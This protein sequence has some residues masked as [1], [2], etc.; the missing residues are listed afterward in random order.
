MFGKIGNLAVKYRAWV[1]AGWVIAA[2]CLF[3]LA[4]PLSQVGTM[5]ESNFLPEDSESLRARALI[6]EYFPENQA[7]STVSLVF[8]SPDGLGEGDLDYSRQVS[9]WLLS[10]ETPFKV[11][12]VTSIF[13]NPELESRLVSPDKTTMLINAGLEKVAFESASWET[14]S[15][16]RGYLES[17]PAGLEIYVSGQVGIYADLFDSVNESIHLTTIITILLVVVLLIIIFRSPVAAVI[18]LITIGI[19]YLAAR[20]IM[21][22]IGNAGISIWSQIDIFL[23][24]MIF[25]IGTDYCL[26]MVSRFR[27]ELGRRDSRQE[28]MRYTVSRIGVVI[29]A[30]AFAVVAGLAGM[31]A[32]RYQMIQTMGPLLGIAIFITL[33]AALT[34]APALTSIFGRKLFWPRHDHLGTDKAQRRPG[35]WDRVARFSTGKPALT[36]GIVILVMLI[37]YL[38]LPGLNRSFD[39]LS[40]IPSDSESVAG[41]RILQEHYDIGEMD[42]LTAIIVA[43]EGETLT[44]PEALE[45]LSKISQDLLAIEGIHKVQS[46][47]QP[48]GSG[49]TPE[50]LTVPGQLD[51]IGQGITSS[52]SGADPALLFSEEVDRGFTQVK[53]YLEELGQSF[54][55]AEEEPAYQELQRDMQNLEQIINQI[56]TA[57]L[58]ENQLKSISQQITGMSEV[59]TRP[60][61]G[62]P[63]EA[64]QAV[65][66]VRMYLEELREQHPELEAEEAFN[67]TLATVQEI[68]TRL[69]QAQSLP[70][71][72]MQEVMSALPGQIQQLI[73][74]LD[75]LANSFSGSSVYLF[76]SVLAQA[77]GENS[78]MEA[79]EQQFESFNRNLSGLRQAFTR[80]GSPVFLSSTLMGTS[81]QAQGLMQIF[82]SESKQAV[83]MYIV[84]N[85]LPQS[86]EA[87]T[88]VS[89]A[90]EIIPDSIESTPLEGA[91]V[92]IGGTSAELNDVRQI[93]DEDFT[94]IIVVVLA[95]IFIVLALLLRSLVA[96]VYLLITVLLS[97]GTTLGLVSWIFQGIMGQDGISFLIPI[98]VFVLLIALGSDYNIFLM[99]RVREESQKQNTRTGT[100]LAAIATGGVITACG[101][102]L[103]GTFGALVITPIRTMMQIGAAVAIG[104][105][106]D[107]FVVRALLV[108]A[109][110]SLLGRWNWWPGKHRNLP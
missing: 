13:Q 16:I 79:L 60:E 70:P 56:R 93:L 108:P 106:I 29:A 28:A 5:S 32:A 47:V 51:S 65:T 75:Q 18:P 34:L 100:R 42:P 12:N 1:I 2:L 17:A 14:V 7:A 21:G 49:Q 69:F 22:L 24:V 55:W 33:L 40:E 19:A 73:A 88:A 64:G 62:I 95:A 4:P 77:S 67:N 82:Y 94:R 8:Y 61:S 41:F 23:I 45:A 35:I 92:V 105:L 83:R 36:A 91:E 39:Q 101:I 3:F 31:A 97:Y 59:L 76:S 58:V 103:A 68:E 74:G 98:L 71:D 87:L 26:F 54:S 84:L 80:Q 90:R 86:D 63:L 25:G 9:D 43:Q 11:E 20:G 99:S 66:M 15:S 107:T 72:Q 46:I 89:A 53:G 85:S 30:S 109:L 37:P 52:F 81:E 10:G 38:A 104:I 48:D 96:P 57:S 110:A 78:P 6:G 102:I 27:E 44:N 50:A